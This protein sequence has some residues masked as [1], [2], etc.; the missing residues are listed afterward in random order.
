MGPHGVN[1]TLAGAHTPVS[2]EKI[3]SWVFVEPG[4]SYPLF[5]LALAVSLQRGHGPG[6]PDAYPPT[7]KERNLPDRMESLKHH[8]SKEV[9]PSAMVQPCPEGH[10]RPP[11]LSSLRPSKPTSPFW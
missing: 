9:S 1:Y 11:R 6:R 3:R 2:D 8:P 5:K 10:Q 4:E 7:L